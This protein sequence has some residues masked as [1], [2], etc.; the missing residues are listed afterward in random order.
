MDKYVGKQ[1][2]KYS[3]LI[4]TVEYD[5]TKHGSILNRNV[6]RKIILGAEWFVIYTILTMKCS[7]HFFSSNE[8]NRHTP[9]HRFTRHIFYIKSFQ[10]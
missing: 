5:E 9:E 2:M 6:P 1:P 3:E 4:S 8:I 7:V 10:G